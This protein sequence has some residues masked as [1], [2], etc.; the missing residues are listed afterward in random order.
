MD[1]ESPIVI[2]TKKTQAQWF[3]YGQSRI[4]SCLRFLQTHLVDEHSKFL[5]VGNQNFL[6]IVKLFLYFTGGRWG[7]G[8]FMTT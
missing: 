2:V 8:N 3:F 6:E 1:L 4:I 5:W 7:V